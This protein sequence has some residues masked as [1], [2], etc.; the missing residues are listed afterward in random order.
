MLAA[1]DIVI[2]EIKALQITTHLIGAVYY[3]Y[4]N[5]VQN[6]FYCQKL[7]LLSYL[8]P[9]HKQREA[10]AIFHSCKQKEIQTVTICKSENS[11]VARSRNVESHV[12]VMMS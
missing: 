11:R 5:K 12:N 4:I 1:K 2:L 8:K 9:C 3:D 10:Q 6:K 7:H